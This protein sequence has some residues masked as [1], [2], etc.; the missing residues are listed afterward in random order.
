[1]KQLLNQKITELQAELS[2]YRKGFCVAHQPLPEGSYKG[3]YC[4]DLVHLQHKLTEAC[5]ENERLK[6]A[7][8]NLQTYDLSGDLEYIVD[9][10]LNQGKTTNNELCAETEKL[11]NAL[12]KICASKEIMEARRFARESLETLNQCQDKGNNHPT[13]SNN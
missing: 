13:E 10:A 11:K 3:C 2:L 7:L 6:D 1:M 5:A 4:C 8:L 12:R 9:N